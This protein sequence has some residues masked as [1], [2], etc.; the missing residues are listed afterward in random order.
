MKCCQ[1]RRRDDGSQAHETRKRRAGSEAHSPV[2][3]DVRLG[4]G[5]SARSG[6]GSGYA[7]AQAQ[8]T[9][10][11]LAAVVPPAERRR[12]L[13]LRCLR[14]GERAEL[15]PVQRL[16]DARRTARVRKCQADRA[17]VATVAKTKELKKRYGAKRGSFS[18]VLEAVSR[19]SGS[20]FSASGKWPRAVTYA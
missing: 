5:R 20:P 6:G 7:L 15:P 10:A 8:R 11:A 17:L 14:P 9:P 1:R 18:S 2:R 13:H 19:V 3:V 12:L 4:A 16:S